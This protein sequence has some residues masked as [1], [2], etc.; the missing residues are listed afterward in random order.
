MSSGVKIAN[1]PRIE[2]NLKILKEQI[3]NINAEGYC[4]ANGDAMTAL[5]S[6]KQYTIYI[7]YMG[8]LCRVLK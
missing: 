8:I 4:V 3:P 2:N 6:T 5:E 7:N 1:L